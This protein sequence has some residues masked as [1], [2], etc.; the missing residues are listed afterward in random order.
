MITSKLEYPI[1]TF[2]QRELLSAGT[3]LSP[4]AVTELIGGNKVIEES[5]PLF[6]YGRAK[7]DLLHFISQSPYTIIF[8]VLQRLTG[9]LFLKYLA[10]H[11]TFQCHG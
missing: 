3:M 7:K 11:I 1:F 6:I 8:S 4:E 10:A 9:F 2:D 5:Y